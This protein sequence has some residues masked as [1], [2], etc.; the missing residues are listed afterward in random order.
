ML[1]AQPCELLTTTGNS[2]QSSLSSQVEKYRHPPIT[3]GACSREEQGNPRA[4]AR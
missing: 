2:G 1:A 4:H 3:T